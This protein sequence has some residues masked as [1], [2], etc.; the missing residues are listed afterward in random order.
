M[1]H[2][3]RKILTLAFAVAMMNITLQGQTASAQT[4]NSVPPVLQ[5][6]TRG[7]EVV[8][9]RGFGDVFSR[10]LDQI[11]DKLRDRGIDVT[12]TSHQQWKRVAETII[13]NRRRFGRRPVIL[14]GHSLGANAVIRL[15]KRLNKVRIRVDY[16][17]TFAATNPEPV[18]ANVRRATNYFFKTDGWGK[19][20]KRSP[21]FRGVIRNIDFSSDT[22]VGHFNIDN[23]PKLQNQV[24]RN[25]LRHV[26]PNR[27]Q[28]TAV[29]SG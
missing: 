3:T 23:Q 22:E 25:I 4:T 24:I 19:P 29:N 10:G 7:G 26:S 11:G 12:V 6:A 13:R 1:N 28:K 15:A 5:V 2:L 17:A 18:P 27:K 20:L 21:G 16:M 8:L 14:I 9:L